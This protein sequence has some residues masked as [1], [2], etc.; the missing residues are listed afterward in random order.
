MQCSADASVYLDCV[1]SEVLVQCCVDF[2]AAC[3]GKSS[4]GRAVLAVGVWLNNFKLF[5]KWN[6]KNPGVYDSV[7]R[8]FLYI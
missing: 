8:M 6:W 7:G 2:G 4:M 5:M 3:C 1:F